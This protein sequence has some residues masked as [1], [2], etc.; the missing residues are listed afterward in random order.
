VVDCGVR[1][2]FG[3]RTG[4]I[5]AKVAWGSAD[6][7]QGPAMTEAQCAQALA[8]GA[9]LVQRLPGNALLLG[10]MGI[11]NTS[12]ASLL[13]ARLAGLDIDV[14]TGAGTGRTGVII[15]TTCS[16]RVARISTPLPVTR[17]DKI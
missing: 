2:S 4:L 17:L 8:N 7:L 3:H 12:A 13:L 10:E 15:L 1:H 11:G 5:D 6:A 9:A 16:S 14:C